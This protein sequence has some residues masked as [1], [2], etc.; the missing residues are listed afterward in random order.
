MIFSLSAAIVALCIEVKIVASGSPDD[1]FS[2]STNE[3]HACQLGVRVNSSYMLTCFAIT[4][5]ND[6]Q[7]LLR[8]IDY[9]DG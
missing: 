1:S 5:I 7:I 2:P 9:R 6:P 4:K 3:D 8:G